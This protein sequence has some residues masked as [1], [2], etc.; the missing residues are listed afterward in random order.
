MKQ[1]ME[2]AINP[3]KKQL[4]ERKVSRRFLHWI[5]RL[6]LLIISDLLFFACENDAPNSFLFNQ[7]INQNLT[8]TM[9]RHHIGFTPQGFTVAFR[10]E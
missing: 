3:V 7:N 10:I 5:E 9:M 8:E 6:Y 1:D 2:Q 4:I